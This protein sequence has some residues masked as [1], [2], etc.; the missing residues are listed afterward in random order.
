M[1]SQPFRR[2]GSDTRGDAGEDA[3]DTHD[4]DQQSEMGS[5]SS[6]SPGGLTAEE[7]PDQGLDVGG[8]ERLA[9]QTVPNNA[10]Q[11]RHR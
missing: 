4:A 6:P 9:A 2:Q 3:E 10:P 11:A 5:L 7:A 1:L 8:L